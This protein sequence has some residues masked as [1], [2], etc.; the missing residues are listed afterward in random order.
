MSGG[1]VQGGH[2]QGNMFR[3][4][5][6]TPRRRKNVLG[7]QFREGKMSGGYV[8]GEMSYTRTGRG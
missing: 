2:V 3:G 1:N 5:C 6:P 7:F 4:E 8:Q